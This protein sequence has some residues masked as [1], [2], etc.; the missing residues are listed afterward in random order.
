MFV[1]DNGS[2]WYISG[3]T[4]TRWSDADLNQLK[5]VPASA[6]EVVQAGTIVH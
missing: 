2:D 3:A 6:F 4:D 1:A 5:T